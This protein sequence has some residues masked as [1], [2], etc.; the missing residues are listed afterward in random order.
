MKNAIKNS[1]FYILC[2]VFLFPVSV[3]AENSPRELVVGVAVTPNF[4]V[5]REWKSKFERRLA[6]AS[7]IFQSEFGIRFRVAYYWDWIVSEEKQDSDYL[8][9]DLMGRFPL[10]NADCVIGL[11]RLTHPGEVGNMNDLDVLGRTQPFSGY[12]VVRYPENKLYRIQ[13]ETVLVHELGHLF[14][15][16]HVAEPATI[17]SP[18]VYKQIPTSFDSGNRQIISLTRNMNFKKG[19]QTLDEASAQRL[20]AAY[21]VLMKYEQPFDFYYALG[22]VYVKLGQDQEALKALVAAR[23]L[24]PNNGRIHYDIGLLYWKLGQDSEAMDSLQQA[25][26]RFSRTRD[27]VYRAQTLKLL[28]GIYFRQKNY[29][30]AYQNWYDASVLDPEDVE[31]KTNIAAVYVEQGRLDDAIKNYLDVLEI[32]RNNPQLA[33]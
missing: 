9:A 29:N 28:G 33:G 32:D 13:E 1:L 8:L 24:N 18:A 19:I 23:K 7:Q 4:K 6:Y 5:D 21:L 11:S 15:A 30:A 17:M 22:N 3:Q 20:L 25:V 26:S 27:K 2:F 16:V 10:H 14:G 12:L 31:L